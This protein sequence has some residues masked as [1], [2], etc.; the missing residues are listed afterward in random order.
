M[1]LFFLPIALVVASGALLMAGPTAVPVLESPAAQAVA[2]EV[3]AAIAVDVRGCP[4]ITSTSITQRRALMFYVSPNQSRRANSQSE[5]SN[6]GAQKKSKP[7]ALS[8]PDLRF[9]GKDGTKNQE[10]TQ[11]A[12]L[13]QVPVEFPPIEEDFS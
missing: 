12:C 3:P 5:Q 8:V 7:M 1:R 9:T 11:A 6:G 13:V 4:Y 2:G 10:T